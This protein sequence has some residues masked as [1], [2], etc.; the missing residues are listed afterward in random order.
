MV[1]VSCWHTSWRQGNFTPIISHCSHPNSRQCPL[2]VRLWNTE[3]TILLDRPQPNFRRD[4]RCEM[5]YRLLD[6]LLDLVRIS[7]QF[8][9]KSRVKWLDIWAEIREKT[10]LITRIFHGTFS[11]PPPPHPHRNCDVTFCC[12][13]HLPEIFTLLF[14][15]PPP[16][17]PKLWRHVLL[18]PPPL[19]KFPKLWLCN[20]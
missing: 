16:T 13:P 6:L 2:W 3:A 14:L 7:C 8:V 4:L 20:T 1:I 12:L 19:M 11:A 9:F 5:S 10:S 17:H 18:P 15:P